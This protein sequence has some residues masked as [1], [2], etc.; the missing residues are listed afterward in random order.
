[1][2]RTYN[3]KLYVDNLLDN[4]Q[5]FYYVSGSGGANDASGWTAADNTDDTVSWS[6]PQFKIEDNYWKINIGDVNIH[7]NS[8]SG[9][10][11]DNIKT[12]YGPTYKRTESINVLPIVGKITNSVV[13]LKNSNLTKMTLQENSYDWTLYGIQNFFTWISESGTWRMNRVLKG[14]STPTTTFY[15]NCHPY[16]IVTLSNLIDYDATVALNQDNTNVAIYGGLPIFKATN[17]GEVTMKIKF[18]SDL[19][20]DVR[21]GLK[22][23]Q[24]ANDETYTIDA[25]LGLR[26]E[27]DVK[28]TTNKFSKD[29]EYTF[30][31]DV[32]KDDVIWIK[33]YDAS[34]DT[35]FT[36]AK[37]NGIFL[38]EE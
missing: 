6:F 30:K 37:T 4:V 35:G 8:A 3:G 1:M 38:V 11:Y 15:F 21:I 19:N 7:W 2:L 25:S 29:T 24:F 14:N 12:F 28:Y 22:K 20:H 5:Y 34:S 23:S 18:Q 31:M 33:T 10:S 9:G 17:N 27:N 13:A 26:N 16:E 32:N 36:G